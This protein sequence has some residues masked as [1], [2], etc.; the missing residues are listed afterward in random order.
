MNKH[1]N[2]FLVTALLCLPVAT[3][4]TLSLQQG[5]LM[6]SNAFIAEDFAAV[7]RQ[8]HLAPTRPLQPPH[9]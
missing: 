8:D 2:M 1:T 7:R 4:A 6:R 3:L 9:Q 5:N